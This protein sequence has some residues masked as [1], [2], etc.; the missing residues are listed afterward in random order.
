[1]TLV[2]KIIDLLTQVTRW[3]AISTTMF[4][5]FFVF[6][7]VISRKFFSPILG[8][9]EI[10]ELMMVVIIMF[11]LA[12]TQSNQGHIKIGLLVD[13]F[14]KRIQMIFDIFGY[15]LTTTA[16]WIIGYFFLN[17]GI[18]EATGNVITTLLLNVPHYPFKFVIAIGMLLWGLQSFLKVIQSFVQLMGSHTSE[19]NRTEGV[20]ETWL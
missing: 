16:C 20:D 19:T 13:R 18:K 2:N 5:M 17:A 15:G 6:V 4:M 1:M 11:S 3:I 8:N 9:V 10:V 7:A 14:P 12:Y